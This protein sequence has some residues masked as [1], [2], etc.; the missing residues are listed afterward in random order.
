M[1]LEGG[2]AAGPGP[3]AI[4]TKKHSAPAAILHR[5]IRHLR[6]VVKPASVAHADI[7][8]VIVAVRQNTQRLVHL[9]NLE[10]PVGFEPTKG[11]CPGTCKSSPRLSSC[12]GGD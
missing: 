11:L 3:P 1:N 2:A 5:P 6:S 4:I 12:Y 7:E 9:L 10:P 8:R